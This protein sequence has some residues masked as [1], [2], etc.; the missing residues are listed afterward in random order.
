MWTRT[1][2]VFVATGIGMAQIPVGGGASSSAAGAGA[3]NNSYACAASGANAIAHS[4]NTT[5]IVYS[6]WDASNVR[7]DPA[8]YTVETTSPTV[9]TF[10]FGGALSGRRCV[11]NASGA[12]GPQ[13]PAGATGA[14]GATGPTG[15]TGATGAT[16]PQGPTGATGPQGPAG[17]AN[18][19]CDVTGS[20]AVDCV[21][22]QS[23]L[24]PIIGCL[25]GTGASA[26][27]VLMPWVPLDA[28]TVRI[29][30]TFADASRRCVLNTA[31]GP[32]G[33]GGGDAVAGASNLTTPGG[34]P[35]VNTSGVLNIDATKLFWNNTTKRLCVNCNTPTV[36]LDVSG[37]ARVTGR[38]TGN[39]D[40]LLS[41]AT[42]GVVLSPRLDVLR[43]AAAGYGNVADA[44]FLG[45]AFALTDGTTSGG[46]VATIRA[47]IKHVSNEMIG[48][49]DGTGS[50]IGDWLVKRIKLSTASGATC[51]ASGR[52]TF[53]ATA[54]GVGVADTV[55]V[56]V[57]DASDT[58]SKVSI[59]GGG[60]GPF[61]ASVITTGR[62]TKAVQN[63][64]THYSNQD[65]TADSNYVWDN[66]LGRAKPPKRTVANRGSA[67]GANA[68]TWILVEDCESSS[69][70]SVGGGTS[71]LFMWSDGTSWL[72]PDRGAGSEGT[73]VSNSG[74]GTALLKTG[75]NVTAK[76]LVAG[77]NITLTSA[78]DTITIAATGSGSGSPGGSSGQ[79]QYNS[80]GSFAGATVG[81]G[82]VF[83]SG[84]LSVDPLTVPEILTN[85]ATL[86]FGV[87]AA[88]TCAEQ[89]ITL[90]GAASND[91]PGVGP[92]SDLDAGVITSAYV[93]ATNTVTIRLCKIT[94]GSTASINK[95][96]RVTVVRTR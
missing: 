14:T 24:N 2:T 78:T 95:N 20:T 29:T 57:K 22:N 23:T 5:N 96:F 19:N 27:P 4:A 50:N 67:S 54:G 68:N 15:A 92:P 61:D 35:F 32:G 6:A 49:Y 39:L 69:A 45:S 55:K 87:I 81:N 79:L 75:T 31:G 86:N 26:K 88:S 59:T 8:T 11:V 40:L 63:D 73:V 12:T 3:A 93:S 58:Y 60:S 48:V 21:H 44:G 47:R 41:N 83:S 74:A 46:T 52:F 51:D 16:G 71:K 56:C 62:F 43:Y 89:T 82:L 90:T 53:E 33:G 80:S 38:I 64:Q 36:E 37:A 66:L 7:I 9:A 91:F 70:C 17:G 65:N 18:Q 94:S 76:T 84:L 42:H 77:A 10:T 85:A 72:F 34:V 1:L 28:N 13:G 25:T 30:P